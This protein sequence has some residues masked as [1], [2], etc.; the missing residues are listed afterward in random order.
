[1]GKSWIPDPALE[2]RMASLGMK[3][4]FIEDYPMA[5]LKIE[6]SKRNNARFSTPI[7]EEKCLEYA[8]ALESGA[9]F[10]GIVVLASGLILAGNNRVHANQLL[11]NKSI[12]AYVVSDATP[13]II[14]EF[15]RTDNIVHGMELKHEQKIQQCVF[16]HRK[17]GIPLTQLA[18]KFFGKR[19][20]YSTLLN[21]VHA[22]AVRDQLMECGVSPARLSDLPPSSMST[23]YTLS[24]AQGGIK[25]IKVLREAFH[26]IVGCGLNSLQVGEMIKEV[27]EAKDEKSQLAALSKF[28]DAHK[29]AVARPT[30]AST[31]LRAHLSGLH[32]LLTKGNSGQ[33]FASWAE[34][35]IADKAELQRM[36]A[37]MRQITDTF[38]N[39]KNSSKGK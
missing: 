36:T 37:M 22:D 8:G 26:A 12:G 19:D 6:E 3:F 15:I 11:S 31:R 7:D 25:N 2:N 32:A 5:N 33:P 23:L 1:M 16:L 34:F 14:E 27:K 28:E 29:A 38:K 4:R 30:P 17:Q 20:M 24:P 10:P 9:M 21:A 13:Q 18:Q 35:P 39:L